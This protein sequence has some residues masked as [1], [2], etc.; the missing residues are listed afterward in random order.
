MVGEEGI[1]VA[2]TPGSQY[3][4]QEK[5]SESVEEYLKLTSGGHHLGDDLSSTIR[6]AGAALFREITV[7][8]GDTEYDYLATVA[9]GFLFPARLAHRIFS[10]RGQS[11]KNI[12]QNIDGI[13]K[14]GEML[15][16]LGRPG[17]GATTLLKTLAGMTE[18]FYGW[19]GGISYLGTSLDDIKKHF[20]G[21]VVYNAEGTS[22]FFSD[23]V[24][25]PE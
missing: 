3:S 17:S 25:L 16:I 2:G 20:R 13:V 4:A 8:G 11:R 5:F 7:L 15:L 18:S 21:D 10:K 24:S 9:D 22:L 19:E 1:Q 14:E 12:L 6:N 23:E